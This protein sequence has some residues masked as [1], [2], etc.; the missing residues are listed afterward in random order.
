MYFITTDTKKIYL[1]N[2]ETGNATLIANS[3]TEFYKK[4]EPLDD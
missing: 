1:M 2:N 3:F 4:L